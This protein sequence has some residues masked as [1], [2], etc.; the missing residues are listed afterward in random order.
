MVFIVL[1]VLCLFLVV[2]AMIVMSTLQIEV[3]D[4]HGYISKEKAHV[5]KYKVILR[6]CF[7]KKIVIYRKVVDSEGPKKVGN[8]KVIRWIDKKW[9][10]RIEDAS[11]DFTRFI[12]QERKR[13]FT[14][15]HWEE[16]K[17]LK[18]KFTKIDAQIA[19]SFE[20]PIMTVYSAAFIASIIPFIL[21]R[22]ITEKKSKIKYEVTPMYMNQNFLKME[23]NCIINVKT[24]HIMSV[25]YVLLRRRSEVKNERTSNRRP[26]GNSH[27]QHTR[28]G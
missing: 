5:Q 20:E 18:M 1:G 23:F 25:I 2:L 28:Y 10:M 9:D 24:V 7:L 16:F 17:N 15:E 6:L 14:K 26:Y 21:A 27:E 8:S 19:V 3:I 12:I 11:Q 13:I 4:M 22:D